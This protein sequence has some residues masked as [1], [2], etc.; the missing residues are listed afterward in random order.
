MTAYAFFTPPDVSQLGLL[1]GCGT[2]L[3]TGRNNYYIRDTTATFL[4]KIGVLLA[5]NSDIGD[6]VPNCRFV[7]EINGYYCERDDFSVLEYESIASDYNSRIM[8]PVSLTYGNWITQTNAFR[9]WNWVNGEP[10][11]SRIGRFIS[12]V[13]LS[14]VYNMSFAAMPP[15]DMRMQL[16]KRTPDGMPTD[17][18]VVKLYYPFPN[19]SE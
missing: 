13:Q 16:Q 2:I 10:Q 8:W 19:Q 3:C 4:P 9:G 1:G 11:N 6:A 15:I 18:I 17:W 7:K 5:N 14:Q 12:I